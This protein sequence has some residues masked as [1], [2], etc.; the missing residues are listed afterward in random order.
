ML[1]KRIAIELGVLVGTYTHRANSFHCYQKDYDMLNAYVQRISI[2]S[3][4]DLT[5]R[6]VGDWHELMEDEREDILAMVE[7][8]KSHE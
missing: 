7:E 6:Y 3:K 5:Y 2:S 1:Q 4:K 8:L